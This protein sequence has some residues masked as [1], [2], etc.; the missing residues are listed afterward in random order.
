ML[1]L[2]SVFMLLTFVIL[3]GYGAFSDEDPLQA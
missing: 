3:A 2:N 1:E